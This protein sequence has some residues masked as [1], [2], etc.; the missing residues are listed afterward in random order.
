MAALLEY[1]Q[2]AAGYGWSLVRPGQ[3]EEP[4]EESLAP[5]NSGNF[6]NATAQQPLLLHAASGGSV[7]LGDDLPAFGGSDAIWH[8]Q[9]KFCLVC[10]EHAGFFSMYNVDVRATK[11]V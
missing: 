3:P 8:P 9:V 5:S 6:E 10:S 7:A 4:V 2:S 1:A 11:W